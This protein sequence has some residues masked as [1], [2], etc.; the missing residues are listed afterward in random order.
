[1][2]HFFALG[3]TIPNGP[4]T[5]VTPWTLRKAYSKVSPGDYV[6]LFICAHGNEGD[7]TLMFCSDER[8]EPSQI[9]MAVQEARHMGVRCACVLLS[10]FGG[11]NKA[12]QEGFEYLI[13]SNGKC[14]LSHILRDIVLIED[15]FKDVDDEFV[16]RFQGKFFEIFKRSRDLHS[17]CWG[18]DPE[19]WALT[20]N[21]DLTQEGVFFQQWAHVVEHFR[22]RFSEADLHGFLNGNGYSYHRLKTMFASA[23][24]F[25]EFVE[26]LLSFSDRY[27]KAA[28]HLTTLRNRMGFHLSIFDVM[29][30][31]TR[32][33]GAGV[34]ET[35][36]SKS[37]HDIVDHFLLM[38]AG[39]HFEK[40]LPVA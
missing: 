15:Q 5:N 8:V 1:M 4:W 36:K 2:L 7:D 19:G 23:G 20:S 13:A 22:P 31:I 35:L 17:D 6:L 26:D 21:K 39:A 24:E 16:E 27:S 10:C 40:S 9:L 25:V 11:Q 30:K 28:T 18:E 3:L 29:A 34:F 37:V 33:W 12:L 14:R 38:D 32:T